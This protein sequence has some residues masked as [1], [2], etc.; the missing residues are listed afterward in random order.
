MNAARRLAK[1]SIGRWVWLETYRCL[2][3]P[4]D[5]AQRAAAAVSEP[6]EGFVFRLLERSELERYRGDAQHDISAR[7]LDDLTSRDDLCFAA[8]AGGKLVSYSF[9]ALTPTAIDSH[10]RFRF[11][12]RWIYAYKAFTQPSWRGKRLQQ[13]VFLRAVPEVGRWVHGLRDPLGFVTLVVGDNKASLRAF[14]RLGFVP[15]DSIPV[16]RVRSR[17]RLL[18]HSEDQPRAFDIYMEER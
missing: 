4:W 17:P 5:E 13:E 18:S 6:G 2:R 9:F 3:L 16:L 12:A 1:R 15:Y 7:F 10:L 11:P 14:A 8:F